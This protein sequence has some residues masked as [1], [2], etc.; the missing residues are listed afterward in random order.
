MV[1]NK[2]KVSYRVCLILLAVFCMTACNKVTE[3]HVIDHNTSFT[4]EN[5]TNSVNAEH[6]RIT[7]QGDYS[8]T[9]NGYYIST[10]SGGKIR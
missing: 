5:D 4:Q 6:V 10:T 1:N 2:L 9:A 7:W 8:G 3:T